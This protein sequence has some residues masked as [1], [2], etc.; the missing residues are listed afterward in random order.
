MVKVLLADPAL[1]ALADR[2]ADRLP[3]D[4]VVVAVAD[5][6][7]GEFRRLAADATVLVNARRPI[8]AATLAMA[9]VVRFVQM[10]GAGTDSLDRPALAN[11]GVVAAFNPGVNRTGAAEHTL[12]LM[13]ALIKR[14]PASDRA[15]REGRFAPA[16]IITRGIDD[17]A[18]ATV[19]IVGMGYIGQAVA[20][21]LVPFGARIVYQSRR[22]MPEVD[23]RFG[24]QRLELQELLRRSNIVTL[25]V[26]L[27]P[28]THHQIGSA[29]IATM[30]PGSYLINAGRGGLVDEPALRDAIV[31]GHLAGAA[32]D[33]LEHE[34][35]GLN[36]FADVPEIIVTPHLGGGSRNSMNGVVERSTANIRRFLAGEEVA[37]QVDLC[38]SSPVSR[39]AGS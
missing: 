30:P 25:H 21:R 24:A 29:E 38:G 18:D 7:D 5:F 4:V 11:A 6:S 13:L 35:D 10:I 33:V 15:T 39:Q 23:E 26:P 16:E 37:D 28:E 12:M 36:P 27:T 17:L 31:R 1:A 32:V 34:T 19:G 8:D 22:Q 3:D 2:F 9:P 20:E 14:L